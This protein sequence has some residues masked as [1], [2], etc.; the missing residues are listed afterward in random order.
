MYYMMLYTILVMHNR[1]SLYMQNV[2]MHK[3]SLHC[4]LTRD[5]HAVTRYDC[6]PWKTC[7]VS[8]QQASRPT[9]LCEG[10]WP[11]NTLPELLSL[12]AASPSG[13]LT[14]PPSSAVHNSRDAPSALSTPRPAHSPS[15]RSSTDSAFPQE[16]RDM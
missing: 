15:P 5:P 3:H 4:K 9:M 11:Y 12:I 1:L 2:K 14:P 8:V 13:L 7:E 16:P 6:R 10:S